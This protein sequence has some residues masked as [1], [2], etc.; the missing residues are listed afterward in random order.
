[1]SSVNPSGFSL[2]EHDIDI[3]V[4]YQETDAQGHVH[5]TTYINYFEIG[6][7]EMLRAAGHSY[8]ALEDAGIMLVVTEV[9]CRFFASARYDD[10][11]AMKTKVVRS[12][13]VRIR[14]E[15]EIR[16]D[17]ELVAQGWTVVAALGKDGKVK[18]LPTW[19]RMP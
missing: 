18:R 17:G 6:R 19:L 16:L 2:R 8:R 3:R 14:H 11:L 12:K 10:L 15:Y 9:N 4:R 5:H 7:I 1:M 13:G